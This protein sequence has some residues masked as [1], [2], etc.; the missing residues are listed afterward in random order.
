MDSTNGMNNS[1]GLRKEATSV[2]VTDALDL[3]Y[4]T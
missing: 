2:P 3:R 1:S 4:Y